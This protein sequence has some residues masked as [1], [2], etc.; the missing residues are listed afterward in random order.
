MNDV[1]LN[2][3]L[4]EF[5]TLLTLNMGRYYSDSPHANSGHFWSFFRSTMGIWNMAGPGSTLHLL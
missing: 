1:S 4:P 5:R 2:F 3:M